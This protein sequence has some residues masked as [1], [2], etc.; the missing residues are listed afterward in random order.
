MS[1]STG[2]TN[3][4]GTRT[5]VVVVVEVD[6]VIVNEPDV[7]LHDEAARS[8]IDSTTMVHEAQ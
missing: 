8:D 1:Y 6:I 4:P 3:D 5:N 7:W 2:V